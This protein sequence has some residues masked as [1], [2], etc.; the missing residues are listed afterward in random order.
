MKQIVDYPPNYQEIRKHFTAPKNTYYTY[1]NTIYNPDGNEIPEDI[2]FHESI[3]SKQQQHFGVPELWWARYII[4]KDFR[5]NQEVEAYKKQ[6]DFIKKHTNSKIAKE[7]LE[8]MARN[9]SSNLYNLGISY[10]QAY[11]LIR[12]SVV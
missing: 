7:A 5:Q 11:T 12:K 3:H 10:Q 4:D 6:L 2:L 1:G 9:L 8:E